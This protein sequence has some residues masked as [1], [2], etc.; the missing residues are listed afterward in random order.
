MRGASNPVLPV[1]A[2]NP[3]VRD[4]R[5][6]DLLPVYFDLADRTRGSEAQDG[7]AWLR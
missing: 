7:G 5:C 1:E 2:G 3:Y 6:R 4:T